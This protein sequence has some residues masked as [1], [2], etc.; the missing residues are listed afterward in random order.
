MHK[1]LTAI[2]VLTSL[3][4]RAAAPDDPFRVGGV[5][6]GMSKVDLLRAIPD[7]R[8]V[9]PSQNTQACAATVKDI[10]LQGEK[11]EAIFVVDR[12]VVE[13]V[14][15]KIPSS[16]HARVLV[17]LGSRLGPPERK[18]SPEAPGETQLLWRSGPRTLSA[19]D[20]PGP[21]GVS[22]YIISR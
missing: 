17:Q 7:A 21:S 10:P 11:G 4:S 20:R 13:R 19:S 5:T 8:C 14:I 15:V 3:A 12:G 16:M 22:S 1:L 9:P 2:L 18:S 6:V